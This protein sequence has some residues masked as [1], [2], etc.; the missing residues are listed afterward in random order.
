MKH[1]GDITKIDGHS[2]PMVDIIT[3]GFPLAFSAYGCIPIWASEIEE[4]PIA[5]TKKHFPEGEERT[6]EHGRREND[7]Q[8]EVDE[9]PGGDESSE[10]P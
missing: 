3:G 2:V 9:D 8:R 4:F 6:E 1:F 10:E 5:V 7:S